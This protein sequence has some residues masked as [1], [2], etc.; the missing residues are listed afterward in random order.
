M[1]R[2]ILYVSKLRL[3]AIFNDFVSWL[4]LVG[5]IKANLVFSL[6]YDKF[7]LDGD[8]SVRNLDA[9]VEF[10]Q[11]QSLS[12]R[13]FFFSWQN[14]SPFVFFEPIFFF[15][16]RFFTKDSLLLLIFPWAMSFHL[17]ILSSAR[18]KQNRQK[19]MKNE[20]QDEWLP[21]KFPQGIR[22]RK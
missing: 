2:Y 3:E 20:A 21:R 17:W 1:N 11:C 6:M 4:V 13:I 16:L 10:R 9:S 12:Q 8:F 5:W 14:G 15:F 18:C 22:S 19:N 7:R